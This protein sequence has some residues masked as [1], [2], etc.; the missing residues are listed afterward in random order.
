MLKDLPREKS[1]ENDLRRTTDEIF[2]DYN[3][4]SDKKILISVH[5]ESFC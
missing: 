2:S 4:V 1:I 3:N 5:Y